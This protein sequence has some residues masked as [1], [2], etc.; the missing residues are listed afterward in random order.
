[1]S[2]T[3]NCSSDTKLQEV[4][5]FVFCCLVVYS[6][7]EA[8]QVYLPGN[9]KMFCQ[10][11]RKIIGCVQRK[12]EGQIAGTKRV[13]LHV[14]CIQRYIYAC[15]FTLMP[16]AKSKTSR[17]IAENKNSHHFFFSV[18][19]KTGNWFKVHDFLRLCESH[20]SV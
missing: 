19:T 1:M 15:V 11:K 5:S 4:L 12:D 10:S 2:K 6:G 18:Q 16:E 3:K 13:G 17:H 8:S 9:Q 14:L 20:L 7:S